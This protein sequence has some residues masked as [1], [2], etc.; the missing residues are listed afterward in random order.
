MKRIKKISTMIAMLSISSVPLSGISQK[1]TL[2]ID[3]KNNIVFD[4]PKDATLRERFTSGDPL[5]HWRLGADN[6]LLGKGLLI[7]KITFPE[8]SIPTSCTM[9]GPYACHAQ[10]WINIGV[11][12]S[13][14]GFD[15][16][17]LPDVSL[18]TAGIDRTT[19]SESHP[20]SISYYG[21]DAAMG[22]DW[23]TQGM[24]FKTKNECYVVDMIDQSTGDGKQNPQAVKLY[25]QITNQLSKID[26]DISFQMLMSSYR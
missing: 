18:S 4:L 13:K 2:P 11:S 5:D 22:T 17:L 9:G 16:C 3:Q 12:T 23:T 1:I 21:T 14:K 6:N 8:I 25:H 24:A 19:R 26:S 15:K 20:R 7:M 10:F